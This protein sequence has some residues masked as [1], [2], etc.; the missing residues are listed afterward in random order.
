MCAILMNIA[1]VDW[2]YK[3][4]R[5]KSV[6]IV[7]AMSTV[8]M[9]IFSE[10]SSMDRLAGSIAVSVPLLILSGLLDGGIGGGDIKLMAAAG[11]GLGVAGIW[12]AFVIGVFSSGIYVMVMLLRKKFDR[13]TEI[14]LGP[15]LCLGLIL[16]WMM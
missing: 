6:L 3:L 15:F 7:F 4:I 5:N 8:S 14:A 1:Y 12:M 13:K 11:L 9:L 10:I 2:K 16:V